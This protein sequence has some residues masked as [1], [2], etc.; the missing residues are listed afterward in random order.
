MIT[1]ITGIPGSGKTAHV[2]EMIL[3]ELKKERRIYSIGIPDLIAS[4]SVPDPQQPDGI[5]TFAVDPA[6]N[7]RTWHKGTWL[8]IDTYERPPENDDDFT[9]DEIEEDEGS[10]CWKPNGNGCTDKGGLVIIDECQTYFRP[11][12]S[13]SKVPDFIAAFE[14]HRHQGLDFWLL[15]QSPNLIDANLKRLVSRH[16]HIHT[17]GMGKK[18]LEWAEQQ[19]PNNRSSRASANVK[20]YKPNPK[21]FDL[22]RSATAHTKMRI[23]MPNGV[24]TLVF[25]FLLLIGCSTVLYYR[26]SDRIAPSESLLPSNTEASSISG[27]QGAATRAPRPENAEVAESTVHP[28]FINTLFT[29]YEMR[30]EGFT[31]LKGHFNGW[32]SFWSEGSMSYRFSF[33]DLMSFGVKFSFPSFDQSFISFIYNDSQFFA[34]SHAPVSTEQ[35]NEFNQPFSGASEFSKL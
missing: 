12:S 30:Y 29:D 16:I 21:V 5:K 34:F 10:S 32:L 35:Q 2:V 11:R 8:Q 1:L 4:H 27:A 31:F 6:G 24:Y 17:S 9:T 18:R 20:P 3:E 13:S 28:D 25:L 14:V 23:K 33:Q 19:D 15:T 22:Y 26:M 7:P